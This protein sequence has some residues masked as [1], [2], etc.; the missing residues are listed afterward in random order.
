[1]C[2]PSRLTKRGD[3]RVVPFASRGCGGRGSVGRDRPRAGRIALRE[4]E[5]SRGRTA[6]RAR[7]ANI[8]PAVSTMPENPVA[9]C[10]CAYG[11]TVWSWPSLL[12][13][14]LAEAWSAQPG[15]ITPSI[16]KATVTKRT[17]RRGEHGISR[18]P[19]AQ[20]RP[21]V[22]P[23]LYA[24]VQFFSRVLRTADRGCQAGARPSLRPL[25][26]KGAE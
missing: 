15:R 9:T 4:P 19:I 1:M 13:S 14:S 20:G 25:G 23:H 7:L 22:R 21:G 18:Q 2:R 8:I 3:R 16:R 17:R 26:F 12:R 6:L 24:A 10:G 5:A 11:K